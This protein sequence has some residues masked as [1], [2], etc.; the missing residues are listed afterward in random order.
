M[1]ITLCKD[2]DEILLTEFVSATAT[3]ASQ[4][5]EQA[6]FKKFGWLTCLNPTLKHWMLLSISHPLF[7]RTF[8]TRVYISVQVL[9]LLSCV[10]SFWLGLDLGNTF[11]WKGESACVLIHESQS[12]R[13]KANCLY[14]TTPKILPI[15]A[16]S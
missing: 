11:D 7:V 6:K 10:H 4:R 9:L 15:F 12:F 1:V 8:A 3:R 14:S 2:K 13:K 16:I 5:S